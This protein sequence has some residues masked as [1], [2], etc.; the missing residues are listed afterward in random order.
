MQRLN[1][2]WPSPA[3]MNMGGMLM[4]NK[5]PGMMCCNTYV[6]V[7]NGQRNVLST[8]VE[9]E[10]RWTQNWSTLVGV[11]NDTVWMNTGDVQGYSMM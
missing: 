4:P 6:N 3:Y 2:W 5:T 1:E 8:Y 10:R 7:D 11:R 9:W